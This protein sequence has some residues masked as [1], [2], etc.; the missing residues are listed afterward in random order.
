MKLPSITNDTLSTFASPHALS[1]IVGLP[2]FYFT[3]NSQHMNN[4]SHITIS[5]TH[6]HFRN[7]KKN[8]AVHSLT[9]EHHIFGVLFFSNADTND[10]QNQLQCNTLA[11]REATVVV[12]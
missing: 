1:F 7:P 8:I 2:Y 10:K 11:I 12:N 3:S 4:Y 6:T 5:R 9:K